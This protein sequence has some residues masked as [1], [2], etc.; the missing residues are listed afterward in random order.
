MKYVFTGGKY[1]QFM[2][3]TFSFGQPVEVNDK[4]TLKALEGRRDFAQYIEHK[5][6]PDHAVRQEE[7]EEVKQEV[8]VVN[9]DACPKCGKSLG[10]GKYMHV[11]YCKG[12]Q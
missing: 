4:A 3:R 2:G 8:K 11:R 5:Q 1:T 6:E 10:R 12:V 9:V 7:K